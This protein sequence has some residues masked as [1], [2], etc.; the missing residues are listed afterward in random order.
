[1]AFRMTSAA[2]ASIA[3]FALALTLAGCR[4]ATKAGPAIVEDATQLVKAGVRTGQEALEASSRDRRR[5][6]AAEKAREIARELAREGARE[7]PELADRLWN[8]QSPADPG[9]PSQ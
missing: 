4:N 7:G 8:E 9:L 6:E 5:Q 2:A 1:M 3:V